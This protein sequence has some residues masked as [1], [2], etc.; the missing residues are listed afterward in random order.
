[1]VFP[2]EIRGICL[3]PQ[4]PACNKGQLPKAIGKPDLRGTVNIV[5]Y[6]HS[7]RNVMTIEFS[8]LGLMPQLEQAV[9]D[10]GYIIPTP[11]QSQIIPLMLDGHDVIGQAQTGT[12]K[13]A[14]FILPILQTMAH[15]Q[16]GIK[17]L[18]LAPTRELA[19][20][21]AQAASEL[22][23]GLNTRVLA[24]YGGQPYSPQISRL[25]Q[26]VDIIIGTPGRLKDLINKRELDLSHVKAVVLDE[27]DE[28]LSMGFIEDIEEILSTVP[29][30]H[31]TALF[32][33]TIPPRLGGVAKKFMK[34]PRSVTI[35]SD[36]L[37]VDAIDHRYC[38][39]NKRDEKIAVLTRIFEIEDIPSAIIFVRTRAGTGDLV[40]QLVAHGFPAEALS[41]ELSQ[42]TREQVLK[43]FRNNQIKILVATD[44]A[45][46]GLDID[47]ISHVFNFDLPD[48]PELY[49]HRVGRTGRAGKKGVAISLLTGSDKFRLQQIERFTRQPISRI[50]IPR[51][52]DIEKHREEKLL[53][54]MIELLK[55]G[56]CQK[57]LKIVTKLAEKGH[58]PLQ[59]A[60][61]ALKIARGQDINRPVPSIKEVTEERKPRPAPEFKRPARD[62]GRDVS[63]A[64]HETRAR[65]TGR[66]ESPHTS[67]ETGMVRMSINAGKAHG[68]TPADVVGTI[69]RFADIPGSSIGAIRILDK[70]TMVDIPEQYTEQVLAKAGKIRLRKN[71]V[72]LS[73][74]EKPAPTLSSRPVDQDPLII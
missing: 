72:T 46:R 31:Q 50:P 23:K 57:E 74:V 58:D 66:R 1:V 28:M 7:N 37:T 67:H 56:D 24:V 53:N 21:V 20:Q 59:I 68:I 38:M 15:G 47:D 65:D 16:R 36:H 45:A 48:D 6:G 32:S 42:Q 19:M 70:H 69:A 22:G 51:P 33:A 29:A 2:L 64:L 25:R 8:Q 54:Q 41:G 14:A 9:S 34:S 5:D 40:T 26:G 49:V 43:R 55:L 13:T 71:S 18:V 39:V 52:E 12:G 44:V 73:V 27:A 10:L 35:K 62:N 17:A 3:W 4:T 30:D 61:M 11:I 60:A 63:R